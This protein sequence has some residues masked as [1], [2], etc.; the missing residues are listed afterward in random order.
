[1]PIPES[2][3]SKISHQNSPAISP[4]E[5]PLP[6]ADALPDIDDSDDNVELCTN[7]ATTRIDRWKNRLLDLS[8]RNTLLNFGAR[9]ASGC[10]NF[11]VP[12]ASDFEDAL[13][14]SRGAFEIF[15]PD[16]LPAFPKGD[17]ALSGENLIVAETA[18]RDALKKRKLVALPP[19][20]RSGNDAPAERVRSRLAKIARASKNAIA[21]TGANTLFVALGFLK[22]RCEKRKDKELLAPLILIPAKLEK[23]KT[24]AQR[25]S[26]SAVDEDVRLNLT[27]V[28]LLR[29]EF[30]ITLPGLDD[31]LPEDESGVDTAEVFRIFREAVRGLEGFSVKENCA[32]GNFSFAKYLMWKDLQDRADVL[33]RSRI[34]R[35]LLD[36]TRSPFDAGA[37]FPRVSTLDT[38]V[39]AGEVFCPLPTDSSQLSAVC[40]AASGGNFILVGPPGTGK[41][42]TIANM[43]A[44][45]LAAGKTVLFVAEK[46]AALNVVFRRLKKIGLGDFCLELHSDKTD[47]NAAYA[48]FGATLDLVAAGV[49]DGIDR[50][51][52]ASVAAVQNLR[53]TFLNQQKIL[54]AKRANGLSLADAVSVVC[55]NESAPQVD[56]VWEKPLADTVIMRERKLKAAEDLSSTF[57]ETHGALARASGVIARPA[58]SQSWQRDMERAAGT[59]SSA[60]EKLRA[61]MEKFTETTGLLPADDSL[62]S[63]DALLKIA[64]ALA[65]VRGENSTLVLGDDAQEKLSALRAAATLAENCARHKKMLT[66]PYRDSAAD[67]PRLEDWLQTWRDADIAWFFPR[68]LKR[69]KVFAALRSLADAPAADAVPDARVDLGNLIAIHACRKEF[70]EK[71]AQLSAAFPTLVP[72]VDQHAALLRLDALEKT[73]ATVAAALAR[74]A[75]VPEKQDAWKTVFARWID[76]KD[77]AFVSG[78]A[79]EKSLAAADA[80]RTAFASAVAAFNNCAGAELPAAVTQ[81]PEAAAAFS[82][83]FL[84]DAESWRDICSWNSA[85]LAADRRGLGALVEAV[86]TRAIPAEKSREFFETNYCRRWAEAVFDSEPSLLEYSSGKNLSRVGKFRAADE[87]LRSV[88]AKAVRAHLI[89]S[90]RCVFD[91]NAADE[92]SLLR[93]EIGKRRAHLPIRRFLARAPKMQRALKPCLLTSPLSAAQYLDVEAEPFDIVIFDEASQISVWDSVGALARGKNAVVVGDPKQLPPTSFF[94]KANAAENAPAPDAE[95]VPD[96]AESV[97]DE[98]IAC[99]VPSMNLSWHYRSRAESLIAFSNARYYGGTLSTFPAPRVRDRALECVFVENGIYVAGTSRTN[100]AEA[101]ALVARVV[102]ELSRPDFVYGEFTSV[103]IVTFNSQQQ[104]LIQKMFDDEQEKHPEIRKFFSE[105]EV[106]EPVFVKNLENVQGDER[107][108]IY[109]STTFGPDETGAVSQNFGPINRVGGERRLNVAITRAR[110]GMRVFTSLRPGDIRTQSGGMAD[111]RDFIEYART[112]TPPTVVH[113]ASGNS[114]PAHANVSGGA[115]TSIAKALEE[116]GW[117]CTLDVGISGI[118]VD[119]AVVHPDNPDEFLA[120]ILCDGASSLNAPTVRDR[121]ILRDDVLRGLG[122]NLIRAWTLDRWQTPERCV[123]RIDSAL[124]N[125]LEKSREVAAPVADEKTE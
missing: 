112:G 58:W 122:W 69:R 107:G 46:S 93:H 34:V 50:E 29:Q 87:T 74:V 72:G 76:G 67:D 53:E 21:E 43:I 20:V 9:S 4:A 24:G 25:Y 47:K 123:S 30:G 80:A 78:G 15:S 106:A 16:E 89:S 98:C 52:E 55:G 90:A 63:F 86:R 114:R 70:S 57:A 48:Q 18:A 12:D 125:F 120:G 83:E 62:K 121:E 27:L 82:S 51:R 113:G 92:L 17:V 32:L 99:G 22:W 84:A 124:K 39:P 56:L 40:A 7:A 23:S 94:Q 119:I 6:P 37:T 102:A 64:A 14:A 97:L 38:D 101:S 54:N 116:R 44:N 71:Y 59:F 5:K 104:T 8:L 49:P 61:E 79:V 26:L 118:R 100:P 41:S 105:D 115:E 95:T 10:L 68:W 85:A 109:F 110:A 45:A 91:A 1:M 2:C 96:D 33:A 13:S 42:Q 60:L 108:V 28:E 36:E 73:R 35:R 3:D 117:K 81:T 11:F 75:D 111:L 66:L 65:S 77:G 31:V 19:T 103:G 88:S